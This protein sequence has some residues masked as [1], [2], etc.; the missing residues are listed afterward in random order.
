MRGALVDT[1]GLVVNVV[2][3]ADGWQ[4]PTAYT[5]VALADNQVVSP[6]DTMGIDGHFARALPIIVSTL[7]KI[8]FMARFTDNELA[9]IYTAAKSDVE[10][11]VWLDRF[12]AA[13]RLDLRADRL[14]AWV[15]QLVVK[16]LITSTR[17]A[18]ILA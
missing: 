16:G 15:N 9:A 5:L 17:V 11:E 1:T 7:S 6:G 13:E 10:V 4:P 8:E 18:E 12:R 2:E 14:I 3:Y